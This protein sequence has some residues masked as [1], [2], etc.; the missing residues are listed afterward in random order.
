MS[1]LIYTIVLCLHML[2]PIA[3]WAQ[4]RLKEPLDYSLRQYGVIL[5]IALLGGIV[6]WYSKVRK[7]EIPLWSISHLVGEMATSAFAGLLCFWL[8]EGAGLAPLVTAALA[9]MSG[10]LGAKA[11][12]LVEEWG[13][14]R[15]RKSLL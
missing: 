1:R 12:D 10:H 8:C 9:G 3:V 2:M 14:K 4:V 11:L 7:G 15:A 6:N 5:G 13:L